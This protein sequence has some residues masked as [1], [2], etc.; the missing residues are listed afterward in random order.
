MHIKTIKFWR[1]TKH[2]IREKHPLYQYEISFMGNFTSDCLMQGDSALLDIHGTSP[3]SLV[4]DDVQSSLADVQGG[5]GMAS[6]FRV[7]WN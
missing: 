2:T 5:Y 1:K 7:Y 4:V 3:D 6:E